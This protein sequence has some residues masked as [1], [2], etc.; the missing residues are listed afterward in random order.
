M[1]IKVEDGRADPV[2]TRNGAMIIKQEHK[3]KINLGTLGF[4]NSEQ[5][6]SI[7]ESA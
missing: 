3:M 5:L 6:R 2:L 1:K 7:S 4:P